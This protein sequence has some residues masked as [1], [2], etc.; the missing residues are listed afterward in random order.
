MPRPKAWHL[1]N[2]NGSIF[3]YKG[4]SKIDCSECPRPGGRASVASDMDLGPVLGVRVVDDNL[5]VIMSFLV[6]DIAS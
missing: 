6:K 3:M 5:K 4:S 2:E 1:K